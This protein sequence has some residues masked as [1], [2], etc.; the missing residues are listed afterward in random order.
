MINVQEYL[1]DLFEVIHEADK[2]VMEVY[3]SHSAIVITKADNT[4]VTQADTAAHQIITRGLARLFPTIPIVSEEGDSQ[5]NVRVVQSERFWLVDPLDGTKEFLA[6][7]DQFTICVALIEESKPTFGI[8]SAPALG[9]TYYGGPGLGS[10][11]QLKGKEAVQI[12]VSQQKL[13]VILASRSELNDKTASYIV[14]HYQGYEIRQVGSQLKLPQIAEGLA[15]AYP[16]INGPLHL[17]DL[18]AGQAILEGAGGSVKKPD[19][20]AIDYHNKSLKVGN[21]IATA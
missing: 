19:N 14:E 6:R 13:G 17:W 1:R 2:A 15:D 10:Y 12:H 11:K 20:T 16:R 7:T 18:A 8:V 21:F 3:Q 9:L 5:E 4:P